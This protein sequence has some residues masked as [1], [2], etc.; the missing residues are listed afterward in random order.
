MNNLFLYKKSFLRD[1]NIYKTPAFFFILY[2]IIFD[3]AYIKVHEYFGIENSIVYAINIS[4]YKIILSYV[5]LYIIILFIPKQFDKFSTLISGFYL[6]YIMIPILTVYALNNQNTIC[7]LMMCLGFITQ[8]LIITKLK[9]IKLKEV[10]NANFILNFFMLSITAILLS[11]FFIKNGLPSAAA[12]NI[13]NVY[14]IRETLDMNKYISYLFT[15][16]I[17][18]TG[19]FFVCLNLNKKRYLNTVIFIIIQLMFYL[20]TG[21]KTILFSLPLMFAIFLISKLK[22]PE[23][24]II[25]ALA[26]FVLLCVLFTFLI[27]FSKAFETPLSLFVRR[28]MVL[29][30]Q[31]KFLYFDF[32]N[33]NPSINLTGTLPT[34]LLKIKNPYIDISYTHLIGSIYFDAPSMNANTG[35]FIEGFARF[36][37]AGFYIVFIIMGFL[38]K[39]FDGFVLKAGKS[40]IYP[41]CIIF[42]INFNDGFLMSELFII[43]K[44][45]ILITILLF[46][47][48]D[49]SDKKISLYERDKKIWKAI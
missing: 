13:Y 3:F 45:F 8:C 41:L 6:C 36:S 34:W 11:Y 32:F 43:G 33:N 35:Y 12:L 48:F 22:N 14:S 21:H 19:P 40:M 29:P 47:K 10:I 20:W 15:L 26:V 28:A 18:V 5:L 1:D 27:N 16:Q 25:T 38:L 49:Y 24:I 42:F 31:L 17:Y 37:Y 39:L 23:K 4:I 30:A 2:K 46:Y 7:A 9:D 44:V